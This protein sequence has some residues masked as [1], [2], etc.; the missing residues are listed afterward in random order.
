MCKPVCRWGYCVTGHGGTDGSTCLSVQPCSHDPV[1]TCVH[2]SV[3]AHGC[4][5]R[6]HVGG[7]EV[8]QAH[9]HAHTCGLRR[10]RA[11]P[12]TNL[13]LKPRMTFWRRMTLSVMAL[14]R[15]TSSSMSWWSWRAELLSGTPTNLSSPRG[16]AAPGGPPLPSLRAQA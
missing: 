3:C 2:V 16:E 14:S 12:G 13:S 6:V 8:S 7:A 1:C 15:S 5:F 4:L 10:G 11:G 9:A